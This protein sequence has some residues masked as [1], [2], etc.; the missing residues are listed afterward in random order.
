MSRRRSPG[1]HGTTRF[2]RV[3]GDEPGYVL[4]TDEEGLFSPRE[5]G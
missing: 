5:R 1:Y 3:S 2:P 4:L